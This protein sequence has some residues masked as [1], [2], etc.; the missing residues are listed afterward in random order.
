MPRMTR[1]DTELQA[2]LQGLRDGS[3]E[4]ARAFDERYGEFLLRV[5]RRRL[6]QCLRSRFDSI[7]FRQDVYASFF[8]ELPAADAFPTSKALITYLAR[9]AQNKVFNALRQHLGP[10][11]S[12]DESARSLDGS[13]RMEALQQIA[14]EP[15]ASEVFMAE[16]RVFN[17]TRGK[18]AKYERI[19]GLARIGFSQSEIAQR[20]GLHIKVVR[21]ALES[22]ERKVAK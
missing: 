6:E 16:E 9:M 21:R 14:P 3:P 2:L 18:P 19:V 10:R 11:R 13:A 17:L 15:S 7:D 12:P 22:L 8:R 1:Q 20:L 5:I 4:A